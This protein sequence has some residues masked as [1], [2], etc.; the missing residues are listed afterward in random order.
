MKVV[1]LIDIILVLLIEVLIDIILAQL[2]KL[3]SKERK[4]LS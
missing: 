2:L 4:W 1:K 3:T